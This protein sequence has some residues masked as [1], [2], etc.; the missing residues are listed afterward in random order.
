MK[1]L[2][3]IQDLHNG[4]SNGSC[5]GQQNISLS[6]FNLIPSPHDG[7]F[8]DQILS[9]IPSS[10]SWNDLSLSHRL[11]ESSPHSLSPLPLSS[12]SSG[13]GDQAY[14]FDDP[15]STH[16]ASKLQDYH[17][18]SIDG[19]LLA[20][21]AAT[22]IMLQ[23][24]LLSRGLTSAEFGSSTG[25]AGSFGILGGQ[26][27][28]T[29][30][31]QNDGNSLLRN[32][33]EYEAALYNGL[34]GTLTQL[35]S[36]LHHIHHSPINNNPQP[37]QNYGAPPAAPFNQALTSA[38]TGEE[39]LPVPPKQPRVRAR[40]GQAT[41]PH[42]IAERLRRERIADGMKSLQ[43]LVPN[44]NKTDKAS[45]LDEIIDYVK[46]LQLQVKV[47][48]VSR[49]GGAPT[50]APLLALMSSEGASECI[51]GN[52]GSKGTPTPK[53]AS[54]SS[55]SSGDTMRLTEQQVAK[56]MEDDMG[57]AMQY[58]QG[59]GLCLMPI[60]FAAAIS[61]SPANNPI[62]AASSHRGGPFSPTMPG[63]AA[64]GNDTVDEDPS[65]VKETAS[66]LHQLKEEK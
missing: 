6:D 44:A 50:V 19:N 64:A 38:P 4:I 31:A 63:T 12:L 56:L 26:L 24:Q 16:L 32:T 52:V 10:S 2:K 48:S 53:R 23:Q 41:D 51:Q 66:T 5:E 58:L 54:P 47:L 15:S 25:A 3:T 55:S 57:T 28:F 27:S 11:W 46:F 34:S 35:P 18:N 21:N 17:T 40:R 37:Y 13:V 59:K 8:L 14:C 33:S 61:A 20:S 62:A 7:D 9:P 43:E 1:E 36:Q 39:A 45:M 65:Y 49:L 29:Q 60:S 22:A 30:D 42:S